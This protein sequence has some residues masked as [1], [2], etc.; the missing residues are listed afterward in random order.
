MS[1]DSSGLASA[2]ASKLLAISIYAYAVSDVVYIRDVVAV[3]EF[4]V[5][6]T[7]LEI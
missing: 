7:V 3:G 5:T 2:V 6:F 1:E 4:G